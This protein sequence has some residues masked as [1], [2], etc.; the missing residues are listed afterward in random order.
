[1]VSGLTIDDETSTGDGGPPTGLR[2]PLSSSPCLSLVVPAA[3][4]SSEHSLIL[5]CGRALWSSPPCCIPTSTLWRV[6]MGMER[7]SSP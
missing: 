3:C 6:A 4:C 2:A 1:M 7:H 5:S